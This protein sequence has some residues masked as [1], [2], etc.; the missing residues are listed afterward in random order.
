MKQRIAVSAILISFLSVACPK[1]EGPI[2]PQVATAVPFE[3]T[4]FGATIDSA[5]YKVWSDSSWESFHAR[6]DVNGIVCTVVRTSSNAYYYYSIAGYAGFSPQGSDL[7][8]FDTPMGPLP[9]TVYF[10]KK[11][12]RSTTFSYQGYN[13]AMTTEHT[14]LDTVSVTLGFGSFHGCPHFGYSSIL[15]GAGQSETSRMETWEAAGPGNI[16][17]LKLSAPYY[18]SGVTTTMVRGRVNGKGW[19]MPF[20]RASTVETSLFQGGSG[21]VTNGALFGLFLLDRGLLPRSH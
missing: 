4:G 5:Y 21:S 9:E 20:P 15:S 13:F 2:S 3:L 12:S 8:M 11:I 16:K 18:T 10:G 1:S 14:L 6:V 7:I 19:G 17:Q